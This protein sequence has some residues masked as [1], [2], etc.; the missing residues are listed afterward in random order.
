[1]GVGPRLWGFLWAVKK[2]YADWAGLLLQP[3][4]YESMRIKFP[5]LELK[6]M[7]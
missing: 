4:E 7:E 6:D 2:S 3:S 1:M 5:A